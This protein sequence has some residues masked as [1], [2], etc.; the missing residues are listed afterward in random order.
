MMRLINF[1]AGFIAGVV[2]GGAVAML[3]VPQ[4]GTETQKLIR[5]RVEAI[6]EE[7]RQAAEAA[8]SDAHARIADLKAQ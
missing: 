5:S 7:A 4:S 8:R 2:L 1:L 3:L 6:R